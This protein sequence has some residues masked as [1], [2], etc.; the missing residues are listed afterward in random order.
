[1][2][3]SLTESSAKMSVLPSRQ[4]YIKVIGA[5]VRATMCVDFLS[6][7]IAPLPVGR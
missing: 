6:V 2:V 3:T 1:M 5:T 4:H 7:S